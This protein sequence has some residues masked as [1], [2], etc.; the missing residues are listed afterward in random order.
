MSR[1]SRL[2]EEVLLRKL[3][4]K[5]ETSEFSL[6][7]PWAPPVLLCFG[8][9][10][11]SVV[12]LMN[13]APCGFWEGAR[14]KDHCNAHSSHLTAK[15]RGIWALWFSVD[16]TEQKLM[17]T[18]LLTAKKKF[19]THMFCGGTYPSE[20]QGQSPLQFR[21]SLLFWDALKCEGS[22]LAICINIVYKC[23]FCANSKLHNFNSDTIIQYDISFVNTWK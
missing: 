5:D 15:I 20:F 11:T 4:G 6:Q 2:V 12:D 7:G 18:L 23:Y 1:I 21:K 9:C 3:K 8:L 16:Y 17:A 22:T 10:R 13:F 14:T 19:K